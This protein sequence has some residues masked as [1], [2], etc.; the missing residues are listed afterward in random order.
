M[1]VETEIEKETMLG[2]ILEEEK[3]LKKIFIEFQ[4]I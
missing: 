3:V 1:K 4:I 2:N